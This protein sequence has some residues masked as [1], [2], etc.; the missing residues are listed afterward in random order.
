LQLSFSQNSRI[1]LETVAI[2]GARNAMPSMHMAWVILAW[3]LAGN[4]RSWVKGVCLFFLVFTLTAT[5]GTGEHYFID[6]IV[7]LPFS[8][9][10]YSLLALDVPIWATERISVFLMGSLCTTLWLVLLRYEIPLFV[11]VRG[12]SWA[13][14]LV[15]VVGVY[16]YQRQLS[17]V[18]LAA[19][20]TPDPLLGPISSVAQV[21]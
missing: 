16:F 21:S 9:A 15:T 14:I 11:R 2:R 4:L 17:A 19:E 5:L 3:W 12:L 10:I 7:A 1:F 8:L 20:A 13:L 6:L 18:R